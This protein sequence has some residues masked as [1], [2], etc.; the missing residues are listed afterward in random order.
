MFV[1]WDEQGI[2]ASDF[3]VW[4][5]GHETDV[6]IAQ[7][8]LEGVNRVYREALALNRGLDRQFFTFDQVIPRPKVSSDFPRLLCE[9]SQRHSVSLFEDQIHNTLK[10]IPS[11]LHLKPHDDVLPCHTGLAEDENLVH[12]KH[13]FP[14]F[15]EI[16]RDPE[17]GKKCDK[18]IVK[19]SDIKLVAFHPAMPSHHGKVFIHLY[20]KDKVVHQVAVKMMGDEEGP[21]FYSWVFK[22]LTSCP[23]QSTVVG[24]ELYL[25]GRRYGRNL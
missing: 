23:P 20:F 15:I 24:C 1:D 21:P 13:T 16:E 22:P 5:G 4:S 14:W 3:G 17:T 19:L 18:K 25:C 7:R 8:R 10:E 9:A 11:C 6:G 2:S 12:Q